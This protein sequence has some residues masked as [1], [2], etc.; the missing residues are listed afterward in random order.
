M[1]GSI[2][3]NAL[4]VTQPVGWGQGHEALTLARLQEMSLA[5]PADR[6]QAIEE[7]CPATADREE[8]TTA[9]ATATDPVTGSPFWAG[10]LFAALNFRSQLAAASGTPF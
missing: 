7:L 6:L 4:H 3:M 9:L 10:F 5:L 1:Q 2:E 8:L